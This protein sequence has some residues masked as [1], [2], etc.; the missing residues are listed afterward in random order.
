MVAPWL[1]GAGVRYAH[2]S[3]PPS[4]KKNALLKAGNQSDA[5]DARQLAELLRGGPLSAVYHG[6][7]G[8][9]AVQELGRSYTNADRRHH[10]GDGA[11]GRK[12]T[13]FGEKLLTQGFAARLLF[14]K[15]STE[16]AC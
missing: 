6:E 7:H 4:R 3:R 1:D 16:G 13:L 10:A 5:I 8:V 9:T 14:W 12:R 2:P 15:L 11:G